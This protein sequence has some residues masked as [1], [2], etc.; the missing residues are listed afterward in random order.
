MFGQPGEDAK[1]GGNSGLMYT[2]LKKFISVIVSTKQLFWLFP[3][4]E[5]Q[6]KGQ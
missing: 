2:Q 5:G 4:F 6:T 3:A 1:D